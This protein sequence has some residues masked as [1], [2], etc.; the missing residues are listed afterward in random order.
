MAGKRKG[1]RSSKIGAV[2]RGGAAGGASARQYPPSLKRSEIQLLER[3]V[4]QGRFHLQEHDRVLV[5][6]ELGKIARTSK[7]QRNRIAAARVLV[8]MEACNLAA[9]KAGPANPS[10]EPDKVVAPVNV[11]VNNVNVIDLDKLTYDELLRLHQETIRI[12]PADPEP[13]SP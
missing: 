2:N 8:S 11:T 13:T 3:A 4:R 6:A 12:P 9:E 10:G 5:P 1:R 7:H